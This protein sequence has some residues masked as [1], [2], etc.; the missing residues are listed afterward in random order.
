MA[1]AVSWDIVRAAAG[2]DGPARRRLV[3]ETV[4]GLW[5]LAMRLTRQKDLTDEI[6]QET[7]ARVLANLEGLRP[8]GRFE[9][10]LARIATNLVLE[11][12]RRRRPVAELSD[13]LPSADSTEPW[14]AVA[15]AEDDR[16][17]LAAIW[18]ATLKLEPQPRAAMLLYY[19]QGES[20]D[21]ISRILDVPAGTLK[22]W[23]HRA[24]IEVRRGAE[25]LLRGQTAIGRAATGEAS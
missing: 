18:A 11:R 13:A 1:D 6:V 12:W 23:L 4:D 14:Q 8:D 9:G 22:T 5:S 24:R 3:E 21:E 15:D 16:R 19:A 20:Y 10:Y 7:Y 17:R 2:G 25:A